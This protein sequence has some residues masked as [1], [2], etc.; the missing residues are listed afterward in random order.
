M[1]PQDQTRM[2][3]DAGECDIDGM[4]RVNTNCKAKAESSSS[5][6]ADDQINKDI[7]QRHHNFRRN[8][9]DYCLRT[10]AVSRYSVCN[11]MADAVGKQ[12]KIRGRKG[13]R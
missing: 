11:P 7:H 6:N 2:T 3:P 4:L 1:A 8:E 10:A 12:R 5:I 13:G 9:D